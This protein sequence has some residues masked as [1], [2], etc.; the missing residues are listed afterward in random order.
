MN[1]REL[2]FNGTERLVVRSMAS[3]IPCAYQG[4]KKESFHKKLKVETKYIYLK[5]IWNK[6]NF[7][8]PHM[9]RAWFD[10]FKAQW[11]ISFNNDHYRV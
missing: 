4:C 2:T 10:K 11:K 3:A 8:I 1:W 9:D 7:R 5:G 6:K